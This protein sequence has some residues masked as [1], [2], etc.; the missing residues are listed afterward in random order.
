M[1]QPDP[2]LVSPGDLNK[3][4]D[5]LEWLK[6]NRFRQPELN[7]YI[8]MLIAVAVLFAMYTGFLLSCFRTPPSAPA[9][10][11]KQS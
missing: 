6:K 9:I 1:T 5:V 10:H 2:R 3:E 8:Y 11:P 7:V 4:E